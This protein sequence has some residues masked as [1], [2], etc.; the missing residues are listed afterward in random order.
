[1]I[2]TLVM[3]NLLTWIWTLLCIVGSDR[4][5]FH[6]Y[7]IEPFHAWWTL[8]RVFRGKA[9]IWNLTKSDV[10]RNTWICSEFHEPKS[11]V[12]DLFKYLRGSSIKYVRSDFAALR[13]YCVKL[14]KNVESKHQKEPEGWRLRFLTVRGRR[15]WIILVVWIAHI[16]FLLCNEPAKK[17]LWRT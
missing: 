11:Y 14:S 10:A 5:L 8:S 17:E 9:K 2:G 6:K 4:P 15:K 1:M 12:T 3:K 7:F 16:L 13:N